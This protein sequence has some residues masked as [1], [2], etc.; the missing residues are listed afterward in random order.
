[1]LLQ[2]GCQVTNNTAAN[3]GGLFCIGN[4]S[5]TL[6]DSSIQYN[7][8]KTFGGGADIGG[9]AMASPLVVVVNTALS[10]V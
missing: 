1:M 6:G 4:S 2:Q 3:G 10:C 7:V 8:A 9:N 5:V